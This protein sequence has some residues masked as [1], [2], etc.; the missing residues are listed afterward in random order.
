M[1][2]VLAT[3]L[4]LLLSI[5]ACS[6]DTDGEAPS[7]QAPSAAATAAEKPAAVPTTENG[8]TNLLLVTLDTT[9]GDALGAYG[10]RLDASPNI[11]RLAA[12]G[13]LFEQAVSSSPQTLPSHSTLFTGKYPYVH[14]VRANSGYV[15]S[16]QNITIA[17]VLR[18]AGYRT[19]AEVAALVMQE[20]TQI[21]QGFDHYR[22]ADTPGVKRKRIRYSKGEIREKELAVRVASDISRRGIEF[23]RG[24]RERKFFLWLHY[25]DPHEPYSAPAA[26]NAKIPSSP[27]HAE[28]AS[29]D[30]QIG[31][32]IDELERLGLRERTLV[33]LTSDHG[34]GLGDHGEWTHSYFVYQSTMHVPLI[35][36]GPSS[37]LPGTRIHSPVRTVDIAPTILELL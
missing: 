23:I 28:L 36:W 17:E 32:V 30:S 25:F 6:V 16:E 1:S 3:A 8:P 10:Q 34:E 33:V 15:L 22:G 4:A 29:A 26:F 5:A 11:D 2:G 37:L 13:V 9:R 35:F 7:K 18:D 19:G 21:T 14:G 20:A 12:G 24:N 31:P 27:Y